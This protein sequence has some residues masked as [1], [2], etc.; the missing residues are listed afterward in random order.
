VE[1]KYYLDLVVP[2]KTDIEQYSEY[3]V[4]AV[5]ND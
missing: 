1:N 2:E 3:V 4:Q 5:G